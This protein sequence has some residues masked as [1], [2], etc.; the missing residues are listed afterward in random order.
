MDDGRPWLDMAHVISNLNKL[1][2]GVS[3]KITLMS[4][5]EQSVL[6]IS[7]EELKK[8]LEQVISLQFLIFK[9]YSRVSKNMGCIEVALTFVLSF[10]NCTRNI[11]KD[12]IFK[13]LFLLLN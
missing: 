9:L 2:A 11:Q 6:V 1:D 10:L 3:D 13:R 4:R 7:Y 8:C 12:A 5:D